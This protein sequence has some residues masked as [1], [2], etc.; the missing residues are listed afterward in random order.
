MTAAQNQHYVPKF[1]LRQFLSDT[2]KEQVSVFDKKMNKTFSTSIKNIMAERRF[3]DF[4]FEDLIIT[5]EDMAGR[6][7]NH[8]VPAFN[9]VIHQ[10][11]LATGDQQERVDLALLLAFQFARTKSNRQM[12]MDLKTTIMSKVASSATPEMLTNF[13]ASDDDEESIKKASLLALREEVPR[14]M[15]IIAHKVFFLMSAPEGRSFYLGDDPVVLHNENRFEPY[16][17]LGL[18]VKGIQISMPLTSDLLLCAWCPT[19]TEDLDDQIAQRLPEAR[20]IL[21]QLV[22]NGSISPAQMKRDLEGFTK[23]HSEIKSA[24]AS[25]KPLKLTSQNMDFYNA[26]QMATAHRY[27][28]CQ[29]ADFDL[30]RRFNAE[31]PGMRRLFQVS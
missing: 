19:V 31:H 21:L 6:L 3:N 24:I 1:I 18:A 20:R 11:S 30:A 26:K 22:L 12:M 2:A 9:T 14:Y 7:E 16:G 17:S 23:P 8:S 10:R 15:E 5:F 28:I 13:F 25:G 29:K 4:V 27:I